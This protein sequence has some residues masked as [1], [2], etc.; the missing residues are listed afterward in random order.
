MLLLKCLTLVVI[1]P[2]QPLTHG[3]TNRNTE[4]PKSVISEDRKPHHGEG[5]VTAVTSVTNELPENMKRPSNA[6]TL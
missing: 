5:G 3:I 1:V 6:L 2:R 4:G